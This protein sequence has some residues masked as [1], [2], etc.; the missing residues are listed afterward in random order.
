MSA[1][2]GALAAGISAT[3]GAASSAVSEVRSQKKWEKRQKLLEEQQI[4]AEKRQYDYNKQ[5]QDYVYGQNLEQ[6]NRENAYNTP[7]AQMQRFKGAGLNAN[8]IYGSENLAA[9]SPTMQIGDV[10]GG[11]PPVAGEP[12][13]QPT[14]FDY[15]GAAAL[16]I[17]RSVADAQID[18]LKADTL[19]VIS[20]NALKSGT[21][22]ANI[23][24]AYADLANT[25]ADT[26][27]TESKTAGQEIENS[28][29]EN[30]AP[31]KIE[32]AK[33]DLA[34]TKRQGL[35]LEKTGKLIDAQVTNL[36]LDSRLKSIQYE[37]KEYEKKISSVA[38]ENA[39][40][41]T[42]LEN[43]LL[44]KK[45]AFANNQ[46]AYVGKQLASYDAELQA[47]LAVASAEAFN[48]QAFGNL[49]S[50]KDEYQKFINQLNDILLN[51]EADVD[52]G[53]YLK[54]LILKNLNETSIIEVFKVLN[55]IDSS[56]K[57]KGDGINVDV[58][59]GNP[60]PQND[61]PSEPSPTAH[62]M[63]EWFKKKWGID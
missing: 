31:T 58:F 9:N 11:A 55:D 26:E 19:G 60:L 23:E 49:A 59:D 4:R 28:V 25:V 61:A 32:Q 8:L 51:P 5:L 2:A 40:L 20:D 37:I 53:T 14:G 56:E 7:A 62:G 10:G 47:K 46:T 35:N 48:R 44:S 6:W 30:I 50:S 27:L 17:Q 12:T 15:L 3:A 18:K 34:N 38:A 57:K 29:N 54:A 43:D 22:S 21:L 45:I 41:R 52:N 42:E 33:E 1:A 36:K 63:P 13:I 16:D 24:K 39:Q